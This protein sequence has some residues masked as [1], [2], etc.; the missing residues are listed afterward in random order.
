MLK[1]LS[2][3]LS[4][5]SAFSIDVTPLSLGIETSGGFMTKIV[6][7]QTVIPNKKSQTFFTRKDTFTIAIFEGERASVKNN[8]KLG[9]FD[10]H[11]HVIAPPAKIEVTFEID[12]NSVLTVYAT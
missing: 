12:E 5:S 2:I 7:R 8:R 1:A 11:L 9:T 10:L 4:L 6:P 3:L